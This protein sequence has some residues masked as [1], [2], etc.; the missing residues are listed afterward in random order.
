MKLTLIDV[1]SELSGFGGWSEKL[2]RF[3]C[4]SWTEGENP[5][6]AAPTATP[7]PGTM[8][9]SY[10]LREPHAKVIFFASSETA[11]R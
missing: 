5:F 1:M 9:Y 7:T 11:I 2:T 8:K 10:T 3:E 4:H 6:A